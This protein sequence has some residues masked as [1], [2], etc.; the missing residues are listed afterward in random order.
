[1]DRPDETPSTGKIT[2]FPGTG[3]LFYRQNHC[4][5]EEIINPGFYT[6]RQCRLLKNLQD[7]FDA[8]VERAERFSLDARTAG[9]IWERRSRGLFT[10]FACAQYRE[11][12][13]LEHGECVFLHAN[14]CV[15]LFPPCLGICTHFHPRD[16]TA[17]H[18]DHPLF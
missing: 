15:L 1:M 11:D 9:T 5:Y 16:V 4:L 3:C 14:A 8:F 6:A 12:C 18:E 13:D 17:L 10:P 7:A 2:P